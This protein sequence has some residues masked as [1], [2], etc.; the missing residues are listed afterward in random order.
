MLVHCQPRDLGVPFDLRVKHS[1][2][3]SSMLT[4]TVKELHAYMHCACKHGA[5]L[6]AV[7]DPKIKV[8]KEFVASE[9]GLRKK[10]HRL[11][12]TAVPKRKRLLAEIQKDKVKKASKIQFMHMEASSGAA[13]GGQQK[14]PSESV[15]QPSAPALPEE[16][17]EVVIPKVVIPSSDD[18]FVPSQVL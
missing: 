17:P 13:A 18:D 9:P 14:L 6:T 1:C 7:F 16:V 15:K 4:R 5:L 12:G 3:K 2:Q 8:P 11:K 10:C